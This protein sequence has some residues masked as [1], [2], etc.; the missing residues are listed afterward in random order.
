MKKINGK[1]KKTLN[2]TKV[3]GDVHL[4]KGKLQLVSPKVPGGDTTPVNGTVKEPKD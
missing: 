3:T 1:G 4:V 2:K